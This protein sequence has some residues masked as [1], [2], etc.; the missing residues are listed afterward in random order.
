MKQV[1]IISD[2]ACLSNPGP[3]GW[4]GLLRYGT[5]EKMHSGFELDSTN[6]RMELQAVIGGLKLLREPCS[7]HIIVDSRYVMDAFEKGWIANWQANGWKTANKKPVKNQDLW[8]DLYSATL[9]HKIRWEWVKGHNGHP[10]N[11]QVDK[12]AQ[13]QAQRARE[14]DRS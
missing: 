4:A 12:E 13:A 3:G 10:D 9:P 14:S 1:T 2:G 6:N 8:E 7:V 11:E 5:N